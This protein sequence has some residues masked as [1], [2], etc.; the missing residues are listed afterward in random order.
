MH[1]KAIAQWPTFSRSI[2]NLVRT[3]VVNSDKSAGFIGRY[4][5]LLDLKMVCPALRTDQN[6]L[7]GAD[8]HSNRFGF[9]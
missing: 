5:I 8:V 2:L 7:V 9:T 6:N 3:S 1:F 4:L